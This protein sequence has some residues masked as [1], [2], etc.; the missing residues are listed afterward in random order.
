M[1]GRLL[2]GHN[3]WHQFG[4]GG[5][6]SGWDVGGM[7]SKKLMLREAESAQGHIS[8]T[9]VKVGRGAGLIERSAP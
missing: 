1:P 8:T 5:H 9:G 2:E 6:L 4:M 7:L 3:M